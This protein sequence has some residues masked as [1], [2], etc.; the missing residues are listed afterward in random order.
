MAQKRFCI[1]QP[2]SEKGVPLR[3]LAREHGIPYRAAQH[4]EKRWHLVFSL[5]RVLIGGTKRAAK[6]CWPDRAL[7]VFTDLHGLFVGV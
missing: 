2:F 6:G 1:I 5:E 4:W 7:S 3:V